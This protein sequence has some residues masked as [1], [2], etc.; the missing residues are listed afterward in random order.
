VSWEIYRRV[1]NTNT[2]FTRIKT[3][4]TPVHFDSTAGVGVQYD[5]YVVTRLPN[6]VLSAPSAVDVGFR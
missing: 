4:T 5:Y 6:G 1:R 3:V 2:A